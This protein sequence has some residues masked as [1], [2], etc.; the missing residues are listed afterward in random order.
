MTVEQEYSAAA[1][2]LKEFILVTSRDLPT[3]PDEGLQRRFNE[4]RAVLEQ[5]LARG[6]QQFELGDVAGALATMRQGNMHAGQFERMVR[7][8]SARFP[9][10]LR[11]TQSNDFTRA[12]WSASQHAATATESAL[13]AVSDAAGNAMDALSKPFVALA[14]LALAGVAFIVFRRGRA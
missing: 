3:V 6:V 8:A 2:A 1:R 4:T 10:F 12:T 11:W 9:A 7:E 5:F 13:G 14:A